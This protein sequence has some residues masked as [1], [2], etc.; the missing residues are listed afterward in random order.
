MKKL[1][2]TVATC[3]IIWGFAST[4]LMAQALDLVEKDEVYAKEHIPQK[5]PIP[6]PF[7]READVTWEKTI[8]REVNLREKMNHPLY[9]PTQNIGDRKNLVNLILE[10]LQNPE[11]EHLVY[12]YAP[13]LYNHEYEFAKPLSTDEAISELGDYIRVTY[14]DSIT[15]QAVTDTTGWGILPN[16]VANITRLYLKE[17]WFFDKRY[18]MMKVRILGICPVMIEPEEVLNQG[19]QLYEKTGTILRQPLFWIYYPEIRYYFSRNFCFNR[20]NDAQPTS[21]D[22]LFVQRRFSSF[23]Y[24]ESNVYNNRGIRDYSD[25][26]DLMFEAER[27]KNEIFIYEHDLWEY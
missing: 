8:W 18:S 14:R 3:M 7:V 19:T 16:K 12:A 9:F 1:I 10:V 24:K 4:M 25:G 27:I 23:I 20:N 21:F 13:T 5:N 6:Y 2:T 15:G 22:D 11:P 26:M 17:K